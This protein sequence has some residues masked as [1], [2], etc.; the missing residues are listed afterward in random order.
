M[1]T[2]TPDEICDF[3]HELDGWERA[4]PLSAFPE[5]DMRKAAE[6]L[7]AGGMTLDAISASNMRH[8]VSRIAPKARAAIAALQAA[9]VASEVGWQPI[10][11]APKD[12]SYII[13]AKFGRSQEL[14]WVKHSRWITA[15][16]IADL[17]G[18]EPDEYDPGWTDGNDDSEP[19]FPTH[20]MPLEPP[21]LK[22]SGEE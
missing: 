3:L 4:Y 20:W 1:T 6:L 13:A 22:A 9:P 18:G 10:E 2:P 8:V 12:G 21:A 15:G 19:C 14:A 16:E 11:S 7:K 17:E 5:P